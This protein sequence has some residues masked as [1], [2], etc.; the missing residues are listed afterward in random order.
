[1][2]GFMKEHGYSNSYVTIDT[3]D[4]AIDAR[5]RKRLRESAQ[6]A[7]SGYNRDF[8]LQ[9]MSARA[10]CYDDLARQVRATPTR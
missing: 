10:D 5:L 3:T 9:H 4:L 6:A 2:R 7:L 1:M 8:Y